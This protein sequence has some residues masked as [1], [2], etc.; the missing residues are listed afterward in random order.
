[1]LL[2]AIP[3]EQWTDTWWLVRKDGTPI[4]GSRGGG[5]AMLRAMH[6]TRPLGWL[7]A[8]LRLS[9]LVDALDHYVARYRAHWSWHVPKGSAPRRFP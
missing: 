2:A 5:I 9:P 3:A 7:L 8:T 1:V 4:P 6:L